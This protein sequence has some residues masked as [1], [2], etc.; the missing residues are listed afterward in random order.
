MNG[1]YTHLLWTPH[2]PPNC[3]R[4]IEGL[5]VFG[6]LIIIL[7][8]I[9]PSLLGTVGYLPPSDCVTLGPHI[10]GVLWDIRYVN[11]WL[12]YVFTERF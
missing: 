11:S 4:V 5:I 8:N 6:C 10:G 9:Y 2:Q 12:I 1:N 3:L 7:N